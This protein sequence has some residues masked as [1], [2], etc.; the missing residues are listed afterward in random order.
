MVKQASKKKKQEASKASESVRKYL[1]MV[2]RVGEPVNGW[3]K[4]EKIDLREKKRM[5]Y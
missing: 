5:I 2:N 4:I 1:C 3:D